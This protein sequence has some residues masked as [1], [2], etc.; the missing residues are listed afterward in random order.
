[1]TNQTKKLISN[2]KKEIEEIEERIR[3]F[4]GEI[5][6][7][8][9]DEEFEVTKNYDVFRE[10]IKADRIQAQLQFAEKLIEAI[11]RDIMKAINEMPI[12]KNYD[13]DKNGNEVI[14]YEI[15]KKEAI[16]KLNKILNSALEK[17]QK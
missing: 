12:S 11:K 1:M 10:N 9:K 6:I 13:V 5:V 17:C 4:E 7:K 2:L 8:V 14:T 16:Q 15:N 3:G